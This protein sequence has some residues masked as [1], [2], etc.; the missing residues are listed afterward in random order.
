MELRKQSKQEREF[1]REAIQMQKKAERDEIKKIKDI[2]ERKRQEI[3]LRHQEEK[4]RRHDVIRM[5]QEEGMIKKKEFFEEKRSFLKMQIE[6][7][8]F[9]EAR[10][11]NRKELE[12]LNMEKLELEL[13]K[14]LQHTQMLQKAAFEELEVALSVKP[15]DY[16]SRFLQKGSVK[17][18]R[19]S[20]DASGME[21]LTERTEN[22]RSQLPPLEK[23]LET[24]NYYIG[25]KGIRGQPDAKVEEV[26]GAKEKRVQMKPDAENTKETTNIE[27]Q[28]TN[29]SAEEQ[30]NVNIEESQKDEKQN[31]EAAQNKAEVQQDEK[32]S[33]EAQQSNEEN[34]KKVE[35]MHNDEKK[36]ENQNNS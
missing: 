15:S 32:K 20:H 3:L 34:Q 30:K 17:D 6:K 4:S 2:N 29:R 5:Q 19:H 36:E 16:E 25:K 11:K 28:K 18:L 27:Q 24:E 8:K 1:I 33:E 23:K 31:E 9:D 26:E 14:K 10:A 13:I 35:E 12:V 7:K 21:A 22:N